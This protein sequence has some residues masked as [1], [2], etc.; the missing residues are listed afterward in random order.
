MLNLGGGPDNTLAIWAGFGPMLAALKGEE[1]PVTYY[2]YLVLEQADEWPERNQR[3][4]YW[5][6]IEDAG[7]VAYREDYLLVV[8]QFEALRKWI[9][10]SA[11]AQKAEQLELRLPGL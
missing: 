10:R 9:T 3:Q 4:R 8:Q 5:A 7:K 2:P 6:L 1:V 11:K